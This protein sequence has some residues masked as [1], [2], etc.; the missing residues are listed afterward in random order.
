MQ[1]VG[2][3]RSSEPRSILGAVA[4]VLSF[5]SPALA[6]SDLRELYTE[7]QHAQAAGDLATATRKYEAIVRLQPRMAEAYANLGNLYYQQGQTERA[8]TAYQKAIEQKPELIGPHFFLGVIAFDEH[9]YS[10]ALDHLEK[11]AATQPSNPLIYS[12]LGYT[13]YARSEFGEAATNLEKANTLNGNDVDVLYQLSKSYGHL[14]D[15]AFAQL[16]AQFPDSV[17]PVL[18]RAHLAETKEDWA[19]AARQYG[20][21]LKKMPENA[22]LRAKVEWSTAMA[23]GKPATL[24]KTAVDELV[25]ASLA[26]KDTSIAGAKLKEEIVRW[27]SQM[28]G[29]ASIQKDG[30]LYL[31]GEGYQVLAY[32]TSLA[33]FER[34]PDSYRAHQLRAQMFERV[35]NDDAAIQEYREALKRKPDL[36]NIHFAIGTLYWK[37]HR[38]DD[39]WPELL[40][41]LKTNAHHPQAL[42]ELGDICAFTGRP[43]EAEKYFLQAVK[44]EPGMTEAHYAL[45]KIYTESG[46]YDKSI[47]QLQRV[48]KLNASEPT[49]HYRLNVVYRK[50]GRLQDA[51]RELALFD[52]KKAQSAASQNGSSSVK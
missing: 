43:A 39:A 12:Y 35:N 27:Q 21:A 40:L 37:D 5:V 2:S 4:L 33:V 8:K 48:L 51:E 17:Y 3:L 34:D 49:A 18:A 20:L 44:L 22:R 32:L 1:R 13:R 19:D 16:Q 42:Y 15:R 11:A 28:G 14:A 23:A 10:A 50:L 45:E 7:A 25:D 31:Q 41:E 6:Q 38:L 26:Y 30:Q 24:D 46:R 29:L 52:Q 9:D 36:Q 47:N